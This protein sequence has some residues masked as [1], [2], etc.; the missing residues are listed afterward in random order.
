[1]YPRRSDECSSP[2][3]SADAKIVHAFKRRSAITA[4]DGQA[5]AAHQRL[6]N[7]FAAFRAVMFSGSAWLAHI[8]IIAA[9][10]ALAGC[11]REP[12][13]APAI[14]E[15]YVGPISLNLRK[16]L[17]PRA[18]VTATVKHGERLEI[19]EYRRRFAKVRNEKG[20]EGWTD[21]RQ[22]IKP[23]QMA[24]LRRFGER[25]AQ[26]PAHG[27]MTPFDVLNVHIE[28]HRQSPSF[29]QIPEGGK[30]ELIG[31]KVMARVPMTP[32]K[33]EA[34]PAGTPMESWSLVR[35]P[36]A[37]AGWVL[38]R[39]MMMAIPD[40]VA[41]YAEGHHITSYFSLGSVTDQG[42]ERD[43][44]LWT[45]SGSLVEEH[46]FDSFR[47]FVW[48]TRRHRYETAYIERNL[49][50][51]FPVQ[52]HPR[53]EGAAMPRFS[54]IFSGRDGVVMQRTYEF[55]GY[56][57]RM[58]AKEPWRLS[59]DLEEEEAPISQAQPPPE[60]AGKGLL[61]GLMEKLKQMIRR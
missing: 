47:V 27:L 57:V 34:P 52:V 33:T 45:T 5:I 15:A 43:H 36:D 48:S 56:H 53:R 9:L 35:L 17:T 61:A 39:M 22:L 55:Q 16:E 42:Q 54:L 12:Q 2:D 44:W 19:L 8:A 14:G 20:A 6:G 7:R 46:H 10:S 37:R 11:G 13:T 59:K 25:A 1:M 41:Q 23:E 26:L 31:R 50:G 29:F 40:E 60:P 21:G 51:Y 58:I 18:A 3:G 49:K 38:S 32:G 30:V 28:P 4:N 24:R